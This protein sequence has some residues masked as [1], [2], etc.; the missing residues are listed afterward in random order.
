MEQTIEQT[1]TTLRRVWQERRDQFGPEHPYTLTAMANLAR[2]LRAQGDHARR[3]LACALVLE[4]EQRS[5]FKEV[6]LDASRYR[7]L[8]SRNLDT[9]GQ[10]GVFAGMTPENVVLNGA[11]LDQ[12]IDA[13]M[14]ME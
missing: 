14:T 4:E 6:L 9:I 3:A 12:A 8:R 2:T 5:V 1:E 7:Y 11:D 13:A 10:G